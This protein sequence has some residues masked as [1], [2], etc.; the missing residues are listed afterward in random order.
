[1]ALVEM[2]ETLS[3]FVENLYRFLTPAARKNQL[4]ENYSRGR[5]FEII[6]QYNGSK[7]STILRN[8]NWLFKHHAENDRLQN[9]LELHMAH[10]GRS[11]IQEEGLLIAVGWAHIPGRNGLAYLLQKEG[12]TVEWMDYS[13]T[14]EN[15]NWRSLP[16]YAVDPSLDQSSFSERRVFPFIK[17]LKEFIQSLSRPEPTYSDCISTGTCIVLRRD[18]NSG[19]IRKIVDDQ[20]LYTVDQ[21]KLEDLLDFHTDPEKIRYSYGPGDS[22][23]SEYHTEFANNSLGS[24][25]LWAK[26]LDE[27]KTKDVK[28]DHLEPSKLLEQI[29]EGGF[30]VFRFTPSLQQEQ[31]NKEKSEK[32]IKI[33]D[34]HRESLKPLAYDRLE[35]EGFVRL[36][37]NF[38]LNGALL[39]YHR[40]LLSSV[41]DLLVEEYNLDQARAILENSPILKE[42]Q[43]SSDAQ[44]F[45]NMHMN[46]VFRRLVQLGFHKVDPEKSGIALDKNDSI[47][48]V[49]QRK[50]IVDYR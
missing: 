47:F 1:M 49:F 17:S 40:D 23:I 6:G 36:M 10:G 2:S 28:D 15:I 4:I 42:P 11:D 12:F 14:K 9:I 22:P 37:K 45:F 48:L 20:S 31:N 16:D 29:E 25:I 46:P 13:S 7:N 27:G 24:L 5:G 39:E 30:A 44:A 38:S 41:V 43:I 33:I 34:E 8:Y 21:M 19:E 3:E 50:K 32:I 18:E 35:L 26:A